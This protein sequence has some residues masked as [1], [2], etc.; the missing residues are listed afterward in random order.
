MVI[1]T[2][3]RIWSKVKSNR[4]VAVTRRIIDQQSRIRRRESKNMHEGS[5]R[6]QCEEC[7]SSL[8]PAGAD[9][10]IWE[11]KSRITQHDV[12]V[13]P[14]TQ[15]F[16][17]IARPRETA[18]VKK[19]RL[20]RR[21]RKQQQHAKGTGIRNR[22]MIYNVGR[23]IYL[24]GGMRCGGKGQNEIL[25]ING[26]DDT[27]QLKIYV[28]EKRNVINHTRRLKTLEKKCTKSFITKRRTPLDDAQY[29]FPT[30]Q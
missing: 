24:Y 9:K 15:L 19:S 22:A 25:I 17:D 16:N 11:R 27:A 20:N 2:V 29:T 23:V 1:E 3:R 8:W 14:R 21:R 13:L 18:P 12:S 30:T 6:K 5:L 7:F 4:T 28:N 10:R 26:D